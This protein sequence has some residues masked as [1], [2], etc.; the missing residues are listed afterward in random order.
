LV[1]AAEEKRREVRVRTRVLKLTDR[2]TDPAGRGE[3]NAESLSLQSDPRFDV[4]LRRVGLHSAVVKSTLSNLL[5]AERHVCF[6]ATFVPEPPLIFQRILNILLLL[7]IK[8]S[9]VRSG[10]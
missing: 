3:W 10:R 6:G 2:P 9:P 1:D 5:R 8:E 7:R 4:L